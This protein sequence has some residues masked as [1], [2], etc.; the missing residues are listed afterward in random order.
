LKTINNAIKVIL[1]E[2]FYSA[3][4]LSTGLIAVSIVLSIIFDIELSYILLICTY[5]IGQITYWHDRQI[6]Y[7]VDSIDNS[8]TSTYIKSHYKFITYGKRLYFLLFILLLSVSGQLLNLIIGLV[9]LV[10]SIIY[11][12]YVKPFTKII[13]LFKNIYVSIIYCLY[14]I[15]SID[16]FQNIHNLYEIGFGSIV[17]IFFA[18][19][20]MLEILFDIKDI[21]ADKQNN[22]K[23]LPAITSYNNTLI[24]LLF[25]NTLIFVITLLINFASTNFANYLL[26][27]LFGVI[28]LDNI[29]VYIFL[30]KSFNKKV[31]I[32]ATLEY[33]KWLI[34]LAILRIASYLII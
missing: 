34:Y 15:Y 4:F 12:K 13:P 33:I 28:Y 6:G 17:M 19:V 1:T 30:L 2:I 7:K 5:L 8:N 20:V 24:I 10:L 26:N 29:I 27:A 18:K 31:Y 11:G 32:F 23:T 14:L 9:L 3:H 25:L 16:G 22:Y 21:K